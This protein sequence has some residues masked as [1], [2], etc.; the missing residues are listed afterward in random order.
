MPGSPHRSLLMPNSSQVVQTAPAVAGP[1]VHLSWCACILGESHNVNIKAVR[2]ELLSST[3]EAIFLSAIVL[4]ISTMEW[5]AA[6]VHVPES[7]F[8]LPASLEGVI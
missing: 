7:G 2:S 3:V 8:T 6:L 5:T 1:G 4:L